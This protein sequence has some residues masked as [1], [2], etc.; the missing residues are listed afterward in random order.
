MTIRLT[1]L[2]SAIIFLNLFAV[3][4]FGQVDSVIAQ[5][6]N[7]TA[8][9]FAGGMSGNGRFVVFESTGNVATENPRNTDGNSEIFLFDY[10]Q[11][12]IFQLT[13][14]KSVLY[15]TQLP[16]SFDNIRITIVNTRPV[17]SNEGKWIALRSNGTA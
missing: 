14:T 8:E 6:S 2:F 1:F 13:D 9:S 3:P 10:A 16:A 15:H 17:I 12:R 7:S 5:L 11:R 4:T